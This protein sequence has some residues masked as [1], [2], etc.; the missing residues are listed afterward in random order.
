MEVIGDSSKGSSNGV[1]GWKLYY[2]KLKHKGE[3][4]LAMAEYLVLD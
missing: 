3:P 2:S 4:V 1:V